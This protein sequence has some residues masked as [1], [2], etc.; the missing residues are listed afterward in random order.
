MTA[1][2]LELIR[3]T[4]RI[5]SDPDAWFKGDF[6]GKWVGEEQMRCT[7]GQAECFC[8]RGALSVAADSLGL[9]P[10]EKYVI[11]GPYLRAGDLLRETAYGLFPERCGQAS[12][13][14]TFNDHP[15][16]THEHVLKV[17]DRTIETL[18]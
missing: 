13:I 8:L 5:L 2:P 12:L 3:T 18:P 17:L 15:H 9:Q 1:T 10:V 16:T 4:R 11:D 6:Y 14:E 7:K